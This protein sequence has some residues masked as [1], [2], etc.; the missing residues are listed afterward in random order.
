[1]E[2]RENESKKNY[3]QSESSNYWSRIGQFAN[4]CTLC[5]AHSLCREMTYYIQLNTLDSSNDV[6]SLN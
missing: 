6:V 3:D 5:G 1:M 4:S 2:I